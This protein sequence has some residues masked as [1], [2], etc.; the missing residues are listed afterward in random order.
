MTTHPLAAVRKW[1]RGGN[2]IKIYFA[3]YVAE[4]ASQ[5]FLPMNSNVTSRWKHVHLEI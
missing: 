4:L 5:N 2:Y 3:K 1:R